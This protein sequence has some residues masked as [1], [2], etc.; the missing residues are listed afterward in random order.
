MKKLLCLLMVLVLSLFFIQ[1]R[2]VNCLTGIT[3]TEVPFAAFEGD[4]DFYE[5]SDNEVIWIGNGAAGVGVYVYNITTQTTE[6]LGNS[7]TEYISSISNVSAAWVSRNNS[8]QTDEILYCPREDEY[9][10]K[11]R[12]TAQRTEVCDLEVNSTEYSDKVFTLEK[13]PYQGI[14]MNIIYCWDSVLHN[15]IIISDADSSKIGLTIHNNYVFWS[16]DRNGDY[17]IWAY[18]FNSGL[19]FSFVSATGDQILVPCQGF[20]NNIGNNFIVWQDGR[21]CTE[22]DPD[23]YDI[24][25]KNLVNGQIFLVSDSPKNEVEPVAF[26]DDVTWIEKDI[27][28]DQNNVQIGWQDI[29]KKKDLITGITSILSSTQTW[30]ESLCMNADFI[31]WS[32]TSHLDKINSTWN[33]KGYCNQLLQEFDV[34]NNVGDQFVLSISGN[35]VFWEDSR[36]D[37]SDL[38][39][40]AITV[41]Q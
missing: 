11:I 33:L 14:T 24:Y 26:G 30:K 1:I 5:V 9:Q 8:T 23:N 38:Y 29:I 37:E 3:V 2:H 32:E 16:D 18:D 4:Q 6:M 15:S 17:D 31:V 39:Y 35:K 27:I 36:S 7:G 28:L 20:E 10:E 13:F 21:N 12:D 34:C 25:G 22:Q 41:E 40:A 19:S